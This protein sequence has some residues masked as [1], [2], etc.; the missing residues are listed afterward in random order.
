MRAAHVLS[1]AHLSVLLSWALRV[2]LKEIMVLVCILA[3]REVGRPQGLCGAAI[4]HLAAASICACRT[5]RDMLPAR[6][7]LLCRAAKGRL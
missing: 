1:R 6:R 2:C 7:V 4:G 5:G 3:V